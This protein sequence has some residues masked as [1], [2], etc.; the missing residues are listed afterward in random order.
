MKKRYLKVSG[1]VATPLPNKDKDKAT[2]NLDLSDSKYK[3]YTSSK[4]FVV[5]SG[6]PREKTKA[7]FESDKTDKEK[8]DALKVLID[9]RNEK[10]YSM[11][12]TTAGGIKVWTNPLNELNFR[13]R[14][15]NMKKE[16]IATCNWSQNKSTEFFNLTIADLEFII[17]AATK[18]GNEIWDKFN[19]AAKLL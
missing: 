2:H 7:E 8:A 11:S 19:E 17:D 6:E 9:T 5:V 13:G 14:L 1:D 3:A 18:Q 15:S 16:G 4:Y 12:V 10:F